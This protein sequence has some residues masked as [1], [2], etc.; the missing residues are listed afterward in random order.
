MGCRR[1]PVTR[2]SAPGCSSRCLSGRFHQG[3][4]DCNDYFLRRA[5]IGGGFATVAI[6]FS[7]ADS[8]DR[9]QRQR[10]GRPRLELRPPLTNLFIFP[11]HMN[12]SFTRVILRPNQSWLQIDWRGIIQYSDLLV[13]LILRDFTAKYKQTILGPL[14]SIINP[15]LTTLVFTLL[16]GRVMRVSPDGIPPLLFYLCSLLGWSYFANVLGA[17]GNALTGNARIF[18]KVYFPR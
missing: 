14:W 2:S 17:T 15:L 16:F 4:P 1:L 5:R 18:S 7:A 9:A 6:G 11:R 8:R 10:P 3:S 13:E 12:P